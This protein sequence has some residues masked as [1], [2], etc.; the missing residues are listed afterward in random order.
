MSSDSEMSH[1]QTHTHTERE[2]HRFC[3]DYLLNIYR[4]QQLDR[5]RAGINKHNSN[6]NNDDGGDDNKNT[7][8]Y[9]TRNK[10]NSEMTSCVRTLVW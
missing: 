5:L 6:E 4:N 2:K 7:K 9:E 8:R 10:N 3:T 1:T